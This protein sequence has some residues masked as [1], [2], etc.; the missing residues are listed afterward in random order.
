MHYK[1]NNMLFIYTYV[2]SRIHKNL[3]QWEDAR[4]DS[5]GR[6]GF[7]KDIESCCLLFIY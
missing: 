5:F 4:T 3:Q 2:L 1:R 6:K 7:G